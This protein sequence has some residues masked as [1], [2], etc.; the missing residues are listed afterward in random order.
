M[1]TLRRLWS[2]CLSYA[3]EYTEASG[4]TSEKCKKNSDMLSVFLKFVVSHR[5]YSPPQRLFRSQGGKDCFAAACSGQ[6]LREEPLRR[7]VHRLCISE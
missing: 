4:T 7:R 2:R 5:L 6:P 3:V 1:L